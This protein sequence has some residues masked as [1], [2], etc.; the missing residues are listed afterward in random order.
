MALAGAVAGVATG[1][2]SAALVAPLYLAALAGV[3]WPLRS[4]RLGRAT[5]IGSLVVAG[6]LTLAGAILNPRWPVIVAGVVGVVLLAALRGALAKAVP[7]QADLSSAARGALAVHGVTLGESTAGWTSGVSAKGGAILVREVTAGAGEVTTWP[8][9]G[10]VR[11]AAPA[12]VRAAREQLGD[13]EATVLVLALAVGSEKVST[14]LEG[15]TVCSL[16]RLG[17]VLR[18]A[19]P[20][21]VADGAR[22]AAQ[23]EAMGMTLNRAQRR[24][25]ERRGR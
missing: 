9:L 7:S 16:D 13:P 12:V 19:E 5:W 25:L 10:P 18:A 4:A 15:F 1:A 6:A 23:A 14:R 2:W 8:S 17:G 11:T 20:A 22:L 3:S 21:R 24:A